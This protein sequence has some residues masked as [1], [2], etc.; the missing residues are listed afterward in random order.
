MLALFGAVLLVLLMATANL[1]GL[2]MARGATRVREAAVRASLGAARFRLVRQFMTESLILALVGGVAGI[3]LAGFGVNLLGTWLSNALG[4]TGGR[5]LQYLNPAALGIDWTVM[6]FACILT[7]CVGVAFGLLPAWQGS[8]ADSTTAMRGG[9][10]QTLGNRGSGLPLGRNGLIAVQVALA[11]VLLSGA[12]VMMNGLRSMQDVPLGYDR[13]NLF[14]AIYTLSPADELAGIDPGGFH[15]AFLERIRAIPGV[16]QATLG[17]VPM[18]GPT[19]RNL[20]LSSEGRPDLTPATHSWVRILPVADGHLEA[21]GIEL[22]AGRGIDAT[23]E[24]NSELVVVLN[25]LAAQEYFPDGGAVGRRIRIAWPELEV[26]G[27][28]VVGITKDAQMG[29]VGAPAERQAYV[30]IRQAPR[31]ATG[32]MIRSTRSTADLARAVRGALTALNPNT[33]LTS[34]MFMEDRLASV[35]ARPRVVTAALGI[36]GSV[37][38]FL[39]AAGLYGT[40]S[41]TVVR[42]TREL[43]LR[44]SLGAEGSTVLGLVLRQSLTVTLLGLG[45]GVAGALILARGLEGLAFGNEPLTLVDLLASSAVLFAVALAAAWIPA[46]R[47]LSIDPMVALRAE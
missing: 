21:L 32:V 36:F 5:E 43:G 38:L 9:R 13:E 2:V 14:T 26:E 40:I 35:T 3:A 15:S 31:L 24:A 20:V 28:R 41:F 12:T 34:V 25:E 7:A 4:T 29:E 8:R 46:R 6:A 45:L 44:L 30:S 17:E 27:A 39:V 47:A 19:W 42:R 1:A 16:D 37:A 22:V 33:A 23:D 10:T 18:G 11:M